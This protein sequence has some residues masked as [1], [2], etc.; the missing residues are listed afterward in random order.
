MLNRLRP[1]DDLFAMEVLF[2]MGR[3][4]EFASHN[5]KAWLHSHELETRMQLSTS[6]FVVAIEKPKGM[7]PM[8]MVYS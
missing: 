4:S 1:I 5:P 8:G 3:Y 7:H 6:L 2:D